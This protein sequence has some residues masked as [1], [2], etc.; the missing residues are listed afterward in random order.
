[1]EDRLR[2]LT[3]VLAQLGCVLRGGV[4]S[5]RFVVDQDPGS[6]VRQPVDQ[7]LHDLLVLIAVARDDDE[8]HV[9]DAQ[10]GFGGIPIAHHHAVEVRGVDQQEPFRKSCIVDEQ[11]L[12]RIVRFEQGLVHQFAARLDPAQRES[13]QGRFGLEAFAQVRVRNADQPSRGAPRRHR[14]RD[15]T[16]DERIEQRG[17]ARVVGTDD[18]DDERGRAPRG[19]GKQVPVQPTRGGLQSRDPCGQRVEEAAQLTQTEGK[20]GRHRGN[21][22]TGRSVG[23][24]KPAAPVP[25]GCPG[26]KRPQVR[27][28]RDLGLRK[29][30]DSGLTC[31]NSARLCVGVVDPA[32][33]PP[34]AASKDL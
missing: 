34:E 1:M 18:A 3:D 24:G 29:R 23:I 21:G 20:I 30:A 11:Q 6:A 31:S 25:C 32:D 8:R 16:T 28:G 10:Q 12:G 15:G 7:E 26:R 19:P 14:R 17:L 5:D 13:S 27:S 22:W 4:V 2:R 9:G 33:G